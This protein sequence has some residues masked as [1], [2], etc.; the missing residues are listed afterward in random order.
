MSCMKSQCVIS[1]WVLEA[2]T[3]QSEYTTA[4]CH[5][6]SFAVALLYTFVFVWAIWSV[7]VFVCVCSSMLQYVYLFR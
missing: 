5:D 6:D 4:M 3:G 7:C 2:E 1:H